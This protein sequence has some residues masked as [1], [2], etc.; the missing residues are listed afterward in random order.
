MKPRRFASETIFSIC[1]ISLGWLIREGEGA[2]G[3]AKS[4]VEIRGRGG[5][6]IRVPDGGN[7]FLVSPWGPAVAFSRFFSRVWWPL[8]HRGPVRRFPSQCRGSPRHA[9]AVGGGPDAVVA[10]LWRALRLL[11]FQ[12][13][14]KLRIK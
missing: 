13:V 6:E 10:L 3:P 7:W 12:A 9:Q 14:G 8:S 4:Q 2:R 5:R 1:G 11:Q